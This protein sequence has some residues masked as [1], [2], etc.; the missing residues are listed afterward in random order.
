MIPLL[1]E[2]ERERERERKRERERERESI[3]SSPYGTVADLGS[4]SGKCVQKRSIEGALSLTM[5][6]RA[7]ENRMYN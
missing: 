4:I 6:D 5:R 3:G 2:R 1:R 7:S